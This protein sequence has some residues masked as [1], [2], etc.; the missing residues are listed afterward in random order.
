MQ[1]SLTLYALAAEARERVAQS[2]LDT[3]RRRFLRQAGDY[4]AAAQ[5]A[6]RVER[7]KRAQEDEAAQ[8]GEAAERRRLAQAAG[9]A[10]VPA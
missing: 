8:A 7:H 4:E 1:P 3:S 2:W 10:G 9:R 5:A 6:E